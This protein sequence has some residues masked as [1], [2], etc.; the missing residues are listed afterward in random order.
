M[1]EG[2]SRSRLDRTLL[3]VNIRRARR[4]QK[5]SQTELAHRSGVDLASVYRAEKGIAT[6][7]STLRKIADGLDVIFEDLLI[8]KKEP[9][10]HLQF[11]VSRVADAKW[12]ACGDRRQR[13]PADHEEL[14]QIQE[15]RLRLGRMGF[16]PWFMCPPIVIA[17]NGPGIVFLEIYEECLEQFNAAFYEDGAIIVT[18]GGA[19][20]TIGDSHVELSEGDWIAYKTKA[21]RRI[22]VLPPHG[23]ASLLWIGANRVSGPK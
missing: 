6:R 23:A 17:P 16:V 15:E 5:L 9:D 13:V 8:V 11:A 3:A 4:N 22:A 12:L 20:V 14:I 21:V 10:S 1:V 19:I 18:K 7:I 2:E